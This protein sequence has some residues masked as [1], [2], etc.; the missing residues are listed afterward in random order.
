M[1]VTCA[2][3]ALDAARAEPPVFTLP[4][5]GGPPRY[6]RLGFRFFTHKLIL[7]TPARESVVSLDEIFLVGI[8]MPHYIFHGEDRCVSA[9]Q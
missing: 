6:G 8:G 2:L 1:R 9:T 3:Y 7:G 4:A 5:M